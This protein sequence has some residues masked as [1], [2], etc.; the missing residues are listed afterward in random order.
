L[1]TAIFEHTFGILPYIVGEVET[2]ERVWLK[3][4]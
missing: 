3:P 4:D 1:Y 2:A